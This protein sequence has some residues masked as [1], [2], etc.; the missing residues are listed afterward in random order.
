MCGIL[1]YLGGRYLQED[2]VFKNT[3]DLLSHRGPDDYGIYTDHELLLGHRRL[4][5]IDLSNAGHQPMV[6]KES[7]AVIVFNGEIYNYIEIRNDLITKGHVFYSKTDTEVLLKSFLEWGSDCLKRLNGMW[8]FA[9]WLPKKNQLFFSRDRFGVKPFYYYKDEK[10]FAFASEP[11]ALLSLFDSC[12]EVNNKVLYEFLSFGSLYSSNEAFYN[13]IKI[14]PPAHCGVYDVVKKNM[15]IWRYWNYAEKNL[16]DYSKNQSVE[17][18]QSIFNSAVKM[19]LR[20]DVPVGVTLSGGLDSTAILTAGMQ[21]SSLDLACFTSVYDIN[22]RG[23]A[24]WAKIATKP[25]NLNPIEVVAPNNMWIETLREI[26]WHMD[27]PGYS[28][29][30]YP[31][32]FIMKEAKDR[33]IPVLLEGQG[34]DEALGGYPQY[35]V[36]TLIE[37]LNSLVCHPNREN[38]KSF[39]NSVSK[40]IHTFTLRWIL[41]WLMRETFPFLISLNRNLVGAKSVLKHEFVNSVLGATTSDNCSNIPKDY[42]LV[43]RRLFHDHSCNILPGLLHYGDS[44]SMAHSI[45]SRLPF[46]D[47]RLVEWVFSRSSEIKI[48]DGETKWVLREYLR[49]MGQENI[50][51]RADKLGYPTPVDDWLTENNGDL[52]KSILLSPNSMIQE[53]CDQKRINRLIKRHLKGMRGSANHLYRLLS[54]ELWLQEC[55]NKV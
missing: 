5:I 38:I 36:L 35:G 3:L 32:W 55:I 2:G 8:A 45:E 33:G 53:Y 27:G 48:S 22:H 37:K 9:I 49:R 51:N 46:M 25:Y 29:A 19:R 20:S 10:Q 23:E 54:T 1:G 11:K 26:S 28:P 24:A 47:F 14:I 13:R 16:G 12:R 7:R 17:E 18:F 15:R 4:S 43:T 44:I 30:V 52:P 41:L 6:D 34:A 50:G 39:K 40:L 31:V 21:Y 42:D